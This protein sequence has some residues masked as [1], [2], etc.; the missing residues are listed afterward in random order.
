MFVKVVL[1]CV[2]RVRI[3]ACVV[4]S[5]HIGLC[6]VHRNSCSALL[7]WG[8]LFYSNDGAIF[9]VLFF[10][11]R[12]AAFSCCFLVRRRPLSV[13]SFLLFREV[14]YTF[15]SSSRPTPIDFHSFLVLLLCASRMMY[16]RRTAAELGRRDCCAPLTVVGFFVLFFFSQCASVNFFGGAFAAK[17][18][19]LH[20]VNDCT[21]ILPTR[22]NC[23]I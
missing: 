4:N 11:T 2:R 3:L 1:S 16:S 17:S 18:G 14:F 9:C 12:P 23:V 21:L 5:L 19:L 6:T 10:D 15:R 13:C 20:L 7:S 22:F 8:M